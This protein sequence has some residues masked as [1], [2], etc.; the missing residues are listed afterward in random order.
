MCSLTPSSK[1]KDEVRSTIITSIVHIRNLG[2]GEVSCFSQAM[3]LS[4]I[5]YRPHRARPCRAF[6]FWHCPRCLSVDSGHSV[7][8]IHL[9]WMRAATLR[10]IHS[11]AGCGPTRNQ[12]TR[13]RGENEHPGL[14]KELAVKR[15]T[16]QVSLCGL[17]GS[18]RPRATSQVNGRG[19]PT[20]HSHRA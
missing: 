9:G 15:V 4:R 19:R 7:K 13:M 10:Q 11:P 1:Q 2:H 12:E 16:P 18:D 3:A 8:L 20:W 5:I 17:C 6:N 14:L